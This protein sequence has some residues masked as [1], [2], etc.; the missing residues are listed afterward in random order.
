MEFPLELLIRR[1]WNSLHL[2]KKFLVAIQC[3]IVYSEKEPELNNIFD[4]S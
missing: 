4:I 1:K 2:G 3:V